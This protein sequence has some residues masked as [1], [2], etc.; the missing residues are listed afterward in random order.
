MTL[1]LKGY[2]TYDKSKLKIQLLLSRFRCFNFDLLYFCYPLRPLRYRVIQYFT[3]QLL[4]MVN[5]VTT[6]YYVYI[7]F[8]LLQ[9]IIKYIQDLSYLFSISFFFSFPSSFFVILY[10]LL[11]WL[12]KMLIFTPQC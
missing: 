10:F 7:V 8:R 1:Q 9:P 3:G 2:Q 11:N 5:N 12:N 4:V 6:N